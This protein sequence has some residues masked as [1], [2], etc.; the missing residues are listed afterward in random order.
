MKLRPRILAL[1]LAWGLCAVLMAFQ[2]DDLPRFLFEDGPSDT[3]EKAEFTF[4]RLRYAATAGSFGGFRRAGWAEDFP[5]ADR[6]F[7]QGVRRLTRLD[8]R[9]IE[10]VLDLDSDEIFN[11]P[12]LYA[13][14]VGRWDF[15][16]AQAKRL[17]EYLLKGGFLMADNFH[18]AA[19]WE[20][21]LGGMRKVFPA[22][23]IEDLKNS[24]EIF[25]VLYDLDERFQV[26]GYQYI[27]TGRTYERDG[28]EPHW[29][30]IRDDKGRILVA[31][32]HNMHMGDAWE[33]AD[34]PRYPEKF[35][36]L[37]YRMGI[38]YIV[39]GMTH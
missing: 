15:T 34:D 30:A 18:G 11:W 14:N 4:A 7:A 23:P 1:L 16:E 22:R 29:R 9:S 39:Y 2:R 33:H 20:S 36:S 32:C 8:A 37:A 38:N 21:F 3:N 17:R 10:K 24:D 12:W 13:V 35:S 19:E 5:K 26:P 25:H 28:I 31:I 6:Q 27:W